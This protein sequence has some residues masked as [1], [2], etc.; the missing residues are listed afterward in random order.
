MLRKQ[1][2]VVDVLVVLCVL[3]GCFAPAAEAKKRKLTPAAEAAVKAAFP[4]ATIRG[5]GTERESGV[6]LFEVNLAIGQRRIEL[7]VTANGII[8]EI[9][10]RVTLEQLAKHLAEAITKAIEGGKIRRIE[11]HEWRGRI[12]SGKVT[13]RDPPRV[14]YEVRYTLRG[15][16]WILRLEFSREA[17]HDDDEDDDEDEDEDDKDGDKDDDD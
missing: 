14:V 10:E 9:E 13:R 8:V 2:N 15:R 11:R 3:A 5:V 16:R 4:Q 7:E 6:M 12:R 17:G 1:R